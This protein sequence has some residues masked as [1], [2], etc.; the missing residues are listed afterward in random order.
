MADTE[1][2]VSCGSFVPTFNWPSSGVA[3]ALPN[4]GQFLNVA[5]EPT[6]QSSVGSPIRPNRPQ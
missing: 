1:P 3:L 2:S 6:T 4:K 5:K